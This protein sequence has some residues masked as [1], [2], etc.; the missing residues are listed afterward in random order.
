MPDGWFLKSVTHEGKD[1]TDTGYDFKPG[2]QVSGI[3][4]VLTRR[5]T[6]MTGTV[7]AEGGAPVSDYSVVAFSAD[8]SKWGYLTRFVREHPS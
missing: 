3:Q 1:L 4:I 2:E 8:R 6:T 5:A 7:Q